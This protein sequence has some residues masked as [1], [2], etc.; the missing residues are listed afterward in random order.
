MNKNID[1]R[2]I[3]TA[4]GQTGYDIHTRSLANALEQQ[5]GVEIMLDC[6]KPANWIRVVNDD[7]LKMINRDP[8]YSDINLVIGLPHSWP[9]YMCED[10]PFI[11]FCVWEGDK[12]P[13]SWI[14][15]FL[16][17]RVTQIWVPSQHTKHA[18]L[19]TLNF[20]EQ[21]ELDFSIQKKIKI[22]PHG[23]DLSIFKPNS[24][25]K[26][27]ENLLKS[28][29]E[30]RSEADEDN[31]DIRAVDADNHADTFIYLANKGFRGERDR[32]GLQ[33]LFKA[34]NE[35]FNKDEPVELKVKI[36]SAYGIVNFGQEFK[37][38]G[39]KKDGGR[40]SIIT[41]NL[42]YKDMHKFYEQGDV[43]VTTSQAESFNLPCI[44][45]MA[46]GKPVIATSFG[47]QSDFVNNENGWL[48]NEGTMKE[49]TWDLMY[50]GVKWKEPNIS[51][52]RKTLRYV[53]ENQEEVKTKS[54][55]SIATSLIYSWNESA[56]KANKFLKEIKK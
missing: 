43:F 2:I 27:D 18:I 1:I 25:R 40:I 34:F 53:Y 31:R 50:E 28:H 17:E 15:I 11:G 6:P 12:V 33:Y 14:D 35:E 10:K 19:N 22:V 9:L 49:V 47:G 41:D 51:E 24:Q 45:A 3:G 21:P 54:D 32:G 36:N 42:E 44:E 13:K 8:F 4:L 55:K 23:V 48:L 30:P 39:L 52:I 26:K 37:K 56:K 5:E 7:E 16:D 38:L 46:C 29:L 20:E